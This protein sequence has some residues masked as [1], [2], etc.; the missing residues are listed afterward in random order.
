MLHREGAFS[1]PELRLPQAPGGH[2]QAVFPKSWRC[3]ACRRAR[4]RRSG[5]R[6]AGHPPTPGCPGRWSLKTSLLPSGS[7]GSWAKRT[8][9]QRSLVQG[10]GGRRLEKGLQPSEAPGAVRWALKQGP[11]QGE[12]EPE[13]LSW[14]GIRRRGC[15]E[16]WA[17]TV[18]CWHCKGS[19]VLAEATTCPSQKLPRR[20][21]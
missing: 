17:T 6:V 19:E 11:R 21:S 3:A 1:L 9:A 13:E 16:R 2:I 4:W 15:V 7:L 14:P 10:K 18:S 5:P 20:A 8:A 12:C